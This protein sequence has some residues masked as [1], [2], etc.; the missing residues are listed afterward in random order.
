[1]FGANRREKIRPITQEDRE[2]IKEAELD[3]EE[4]RR[5]T[6]RAGLPFG[7]TEISPLGYEY[8]ELIAALEKMSPHDVF[9]LFMSP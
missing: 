1:M 5:Q 2:R 7:A 6:K 4:V 8:Y 9:T 3:I